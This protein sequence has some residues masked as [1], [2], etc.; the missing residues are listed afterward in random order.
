MDFKSMPKDKVGYD[1]VFVVIDCLSKQAVSIPYHK[2]ITAKEMTWLYIVF[3]YRYF[4]LLVSIISDHRPQFV[5]KFWAEFCHILG[6][7]LK[8]LTAF[9]PQTDGQTEIMNQYLDQRLRPFVN[10]Y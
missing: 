10:Y 8:L 7:K 2:T 5:S 6:I 4:G 1:T 3:I 9:Y